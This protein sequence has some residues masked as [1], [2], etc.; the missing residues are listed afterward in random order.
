MV[1]PISGEGVGYALESGRLAASWAHEAHARR[2]FSAATL[3]GYERQL[4]KQ[5]AREHL[6]GQALVNLVPNLGM[7]EP[8]FKACEKD[9]G[10]RRTLI[11]GFTGD[12]PV[13]SLLK[14]PRA[15]GT[16]LVSGLREA[17]HR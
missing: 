3:A 16:A 9:P 4:K 15:L 8:F 14:H 6:S 1:H 7:L 17:A 10:A 11:E 5:R 13:Y 12:A 2:D